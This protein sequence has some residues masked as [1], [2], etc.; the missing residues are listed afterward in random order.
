MLLD[1]DLL[2]FTH[3]LLTVNLNLE[4]YI[5]LLLWR[6]L[7]QYLYVKQRMLFLYYSFHSLFLILML[8]VCNYSCIYLNHL[9]LCVELGVKASV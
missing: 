5:F 6:I 7:S 4:S 9:S 1:G 3:M 2:L 8:Y